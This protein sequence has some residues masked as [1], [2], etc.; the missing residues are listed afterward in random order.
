MPRSEEEIEGSR[1]TAELKAAAKAQRQARVLTLYRSGEPITVIARRI[2]MHTDSVQK[3][4]RAS[5]TTG[6]GSA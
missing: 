4:I 3:L 5:L 6:G 1:Q 2:G